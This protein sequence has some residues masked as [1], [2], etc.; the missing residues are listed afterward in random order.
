M[1]VIPS[2]K[3]G[4]PW[5]SLPLT[6]QALR[7]LRPDGGSS[8]S[9]LLI[10]QTWEAG[11]TMFWSPS[12]TP[13]LYHHQMLENRCAFDIYLSLDPSSLF[14]WIQFFQRLGWVTPHP[15]RVQHSEEAHGGWGLCLRVWWV[16]QKSG[17]SV[18][19]V[20]P[21]VLL[22]RKLRMQFGKGRTLPCSFSISFLIEIYLTYNIA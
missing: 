18:L 3:A 6:T 7:V 11:T 8:L 1:L 10:H 14:P 12:C 22:L 17:I 4:S 15:T 16:L 2:S 13:G 20:S 21:S 9:D 5:L 19:P